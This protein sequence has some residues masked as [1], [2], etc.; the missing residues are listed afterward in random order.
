MHQ[1]S[2][3]LVALATLAAPHSLLAKTGSRPPLEA[4]IDEVFARYDSVSTPGCS[5]AVIENDRLVFQKSYGMADPAL[6]VPMTSQVTTWIPYSE[7]RIF[8][9]LGIAFLVKEGQLELNDPVRSYIPEVPEY[10]SSVTVRQLLDHTSGL[11]DYGVLAGPG[12]ELGDR[13]SEDEFFRIVSKWGALIFPPGTDVMYSNTDY[14]L[15]KILIER[16]SASSLHTYINSRM[17][18]PLGMN[19]TRLGFDQGTA[20]TG[21]ALFHQSTPDGFERVLRYRLS[22]VG[23]ISVTTSLDD[24]I[25]F[26]R[27]LRENSLNIREKIEALKQDANAVEDGG[28]AF[29]VYR[30]TYRGISMTEYRGIGGYTYLVQL[31]ERNLSVAT[32]CNVYAGMPTFGPDV[33]ALYAGAESDTPTPNE[34]ERRPPV[35]S[36]SGKPASVSVTELEA[37]TGSYFDFSGNSPTVDVELIDQKLVPTPRGRAAFPPLT[38][39]GNNVFE[40]QIQGRK[41]LVWFENESESVVMSSWDIAADAPGGNSL[42]RQQTWRP[43]AAEADAYIGTYVGDRVDLT[44]YVRAENGEVYVAGRGLAETPLMPG[45]TVDQFSFPEDYTAHFERNEEGS[46]IALVLDATRVKGIRLRRR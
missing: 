28:Y 40:T 8:L 20:M 35:Y 17:L 7:T 29:G 13:L 2:I 6:A 25:R 9:G 10:A 38:P 45:Q 27:A 4:E 23:Q 11:P 5:V 14:A 19:S 18:Q 36:I 44:Y 33:A 22:P 43:S 32:I 26:D 1:R 15:L 12:W 16:V 41:Y 34:I 24:I 37:L 30:R 42:T 46:V 3:A 39:L 31:P 21:H